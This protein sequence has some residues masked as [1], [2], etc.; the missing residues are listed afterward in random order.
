M[1]S[2]IMKMMVVFA[3][4]GDLR[5]NWDAFHKDPGPCKIT[6]LIFSL[7]LWNIVR[8]LAMKGILVEIGRIPGDPKRDRRCI[9]SLLGDQGLM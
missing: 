5:I 7:T 2:S 9:P 6:K 4:F 3:L 8:Q 1:N